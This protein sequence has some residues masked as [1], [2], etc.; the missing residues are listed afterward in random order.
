ME[1]N[2]FF[3][4][5]CP[6]ETVAELQQNAKQ[7]KKFNI[8]FNN[9]SQNILDYS[10]TFNLRNWYGGINFYVTN[11]FWNTR[12]KVNKEADVI[13]IQIAID[14]AFAAELAGTANVQQ[15]KYELKQMPSDIMNY[16][17]FAHFWIAMVVG[18]AI[19][20]INIVLMPVVEEKES[21]IK[22]I[23]RIASSYS[24]L[25]I[26]TL[27]L[28]KLLVSL[29]VFGVTLFVWSVLGLSVHF[30][31][32][33]TAILIVLFLVSIM[34]YTLFISV[35]FHSGKIQNFWWNANY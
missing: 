28:I 26:F 7:N 31:Y 6:F 1:N 33:L 19:S 29:I 30:S 18:Y 2:T 34:A 27:V 8:V 22:E 4:E 15:T 23:L 35:F 11:F 14:N 32:L 20:L 24:F 25:N 3:S 12:D 9:S 21:G 16:Y 10:V 13:N 5:Y 17:Q